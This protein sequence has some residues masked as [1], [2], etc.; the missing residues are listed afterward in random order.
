MSKVKGNFTV[1]EP[2]CG[3]KAGITAA[4][5]KLTGEVK[6]SCAQCGA[7]AKV[8][9]LIET[10]RGMNALA[11]KRFA[12]G[13]RVHVGIARQTATVKSVSAQPGPLGEYIHEV[14]VDGETTPRKAL[15]SEL[16]AIPGGK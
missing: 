3:H 9:M 5:N 15:G 11:K 14:L 10:P 2:S 12:L 8:E 16:E 13:T 1:H 6:G 4:I 7:P